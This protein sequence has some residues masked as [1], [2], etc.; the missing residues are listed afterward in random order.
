MEVLLIRFY[1]VY[2]GEVCIEDLASFFMALRENVCI[3][4]TLKG[5]ILFTTRER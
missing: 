3:E 5:A 1:Q 2:L 4:V